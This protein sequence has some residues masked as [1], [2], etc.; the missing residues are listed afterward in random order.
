MPVVSKGT[1]RGNAQICGRICLLVTFL[2]LLLHHAFPSA[3]IPAF[4]LILSIRMLYIFTGKHQGAWRNGSA[5]DSRS[6]GWEFDSLCPHFS[7]PG[8]F[9]LLKSWMQAAYPH[10]AKSRQG[11]P[12]CKAALASVQFLAFCTLWRF[13]PPRVASAHISQGR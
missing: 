11:A 5:S 1:S 8:A 13:G 9:A 7:P 10:S 3:G 2:C 4:S 6:E 12:P